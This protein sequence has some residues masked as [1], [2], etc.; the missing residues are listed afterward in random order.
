MFLNSFCMNVTL[1]RLV[2]S[3]KPYL[4]C[5][6]QSWRLNISILASFVGDKAHLT[7]GFAKSANSANLVALLTSDKNKDFVSDSLLQGAPAL[8]SPQASEPS[9]LKIPKE[10]KAA[11]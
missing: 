7:N 10:Y 8:W 9:I 11:M 6:A 5:N 3:G 2:S 1:S 4:L